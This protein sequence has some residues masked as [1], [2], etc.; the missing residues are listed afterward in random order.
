MQKHFR[1][2]N[3]NP[4]FAVSLVLLCAIKMHIW[5]YLNLKTVA[6]NINNEN[7]RFKG[8]TTCHVPVNKVS[9]N[10]KYNIHKDNKLMELFKIFLARCKKRCIIKNAKRDFKI[11]DFWC[12]DNMEAKEF[13]IIIKKRHSIDQYWE[14]VTKWETENTVQDSR[15]QQQN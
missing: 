1:K 13:I 5:K 14:L 9:M 8:D 3:S 10:P 4:Q 6:Q 11:T 7:Q 15:Q 2:H 12:M